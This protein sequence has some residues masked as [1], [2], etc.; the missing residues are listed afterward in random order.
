MTVLF[1]ALAW[2]ILGSA[3]GIGIISIIRENPVKA[4]REALRGD[5]EDR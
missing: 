5:E 3:A 1:T 2:I 4:F